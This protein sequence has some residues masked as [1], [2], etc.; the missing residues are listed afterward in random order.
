MLQMERQKNGQFEPETVA[1][2]VA[3]LSVGLMYLHDRGIVFRGVMPE[4]VMIAED[5]YPVLIDFGFSKNIGVN[6]RTHTLVGAPDYIA[7]EILMRAKRDE[8]YGHMVDYWS[9]GCLTFELLTGSP[10][11]S[12][13]GDEYKQKVY[14]MIE[15]RV[16]SRAPLRWV[17]TRA[18]P[19]PAVAKNFVDSLLEP[20]PD[21]RLG[22]KAARGQN[23][24]I[25][26]AFMYAVAAHGNWED[27][28]NKTAPAPPLSR[29]TNTYVP[30]AG[31]YDAGY[32][33]PQMESAGVARIGYVGWSAMR[34]R[35][36]TSLSVSVAVEERKKQETSLETLMT[37]TRESP[38]K[39]EEEE[40]AATTATMTTMAANEMAALEAE[41]DALY[42][43]PALDTELIVPTEEHYYACEETNHIY[44]TYS[45]V[46]FGLDSLDSEDAASNAAAGLE[47]VSLRMN[48]DV[49][50][51]A[52]VRQ[53]RA[54]LDEEIRRSF[55]NVVA[56]M[57]DGNSDDRGD[58][59]LEAEANGVAAALE[60]EV[61]AAE[62]NGA[63][64]KDEDEQEATIL[65]SEAGAVVAALEAE[66][67]EEE[68]TETEEK[69]PPSS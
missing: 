32:F 38:G 45:A 17:G 18:N 60:A 62:E 67:V 54:S 6:G 31:S 63:P 44:S 39:R 56:A 27:I 51:E 42:G 16:K 33:E 9:L 46:K 12:P 3:G 24:F 28:V 2:Y 55:D 7:P 57:G 5:G 48:H 69:L 15:K 22:G 30:P 37:M 68:A 4:N 41:W 66:V 29:G 52:S 47:Q 64:A 50:S 61:T 25:H 49:T 11:F 21:R 53:L 26:H 59:A 34:D 36:K 40:G 8:G 23:G 13:G 19:V 20:N 35:E 14:G 1:F 10:P 58:R 43:V 65:F